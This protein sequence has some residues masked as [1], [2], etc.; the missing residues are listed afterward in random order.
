M[1]D[2][3]G[4]EASWRPP[5][6]PAW[7]QK[8]NTF[9]PA[10]PGLLTTLD[11]DELTGTATATTGLDDFGGDEWYEPFRI[12]VASLRDEA[13]LTATGHLMV[14]AEL[15]RTLANRLRV[16]ADPTVPAAV[17]APLFIT[18]TAR[19]GTSILHELLALD[20][21]L[22]APLAWEVLYTDEA[23][24]AAADADVTWWDEVAPEYRTMHENG[25]DLPMECIFL[26]AHA[27][28]SDQWTGPQDV[29]ALAKHTARAD[30]TDAYRWHRRQLGVL[31]AHHR[32]GDGSNRPARRWVLKAPSH[33]ATLDALFAVY[34]DAVVVQTHRD[35]ARTI[36]STISLMATLRWMRSDRV[37]VEGL[38]ARTAHG[39]AALLDW[40]D[41]RRASGELPDGQF[42]DV[43]YAELVQDPVAA[44]RGVYGAVGRELGDDG[45]ARIRAYLDAKPKAKHGEHRY[46]PAAFGL[47]EDDL[48]A[49]YGGY[50]ERHDIARER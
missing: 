38:A 15:L 1:A 25:G 26:T 33:L 14:R 46:S 45:A 35:P 37:N 27:F 11:A 44:L 40:V 19:S 30:H 13:E 32:S 48:Q 17:A 49:R 47:D 3:R 6:R 36:P 9:A 41:A 22:R 23:A 5:A 24:R 39:T 34:P 20:P 42:V 21:E 4:A 7:V 16:V 8:L 50:C 29:P 28:L 31:G 18:G 12:F 43:A 10:V 2:A